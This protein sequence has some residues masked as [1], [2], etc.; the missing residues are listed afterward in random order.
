VP[1][2]QI[3][4]MQDEPNGVIDQPLEQNHFFP[5]NKT[6]LDPLPRAPPKSTRHQI[7]PGKANIHSP[8]A[9][10]GMTHHISDHDRLF[11]RHGSNIEKDQETE[12][13]Q[14]SVRAQKGAVLE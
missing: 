9:N 2:L 3:E 8:N 12:R 4:Q 7:N 13:I 1:D 10:S 5:S 11:H 14:R 6:F